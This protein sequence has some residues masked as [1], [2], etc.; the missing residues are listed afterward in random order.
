MSSWD[1]LSDSDAI[2]DN[3]CLCSRGVAKTVERG[4]AWDLGSEKGEASREAVPVRIQV[5]KMN[6][7]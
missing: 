2:E 6:G 3:R 4:L 1:E 5:G 7:F